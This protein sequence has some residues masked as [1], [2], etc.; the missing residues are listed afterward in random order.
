MDY[1]NNE[2]G[3]SL[4]SF[5]KDPYDC[6]KDCEKKAKNYELYWF[7]AVPGRDPHHDLPTDYPGFEIDTAGNY[8]VSEPSTAYPP[9]FIGTGSTCKPGKPC[10]PYSGSK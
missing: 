10:T 3:L 4:A 8:T 1:H 9:V 7:Q 2:V 5:M 6:M